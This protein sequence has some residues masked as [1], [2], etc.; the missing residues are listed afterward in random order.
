MLIVRLQAAPACSSAQEAHDTLLAAWQ[1]VHRDCQSSP[2]YQ[3]ALAKR[4]LCAEHGWRDLDKTVCYLDSSEQP[5]IRIYLHRDGSMVIQRMEKANTE[6]LFT[7][8]GKRQMA[9]AERS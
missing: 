7:S 4:R 6:I 9:S 1:Q 8:P 3:S 2:R 5:P